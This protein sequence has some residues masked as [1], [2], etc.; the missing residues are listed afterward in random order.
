M[1]T[2]TFHSADRRIDG[3]VVEGH[4]GYAEAGSDIVCAAISSVVGVTECTI[5][6]VLGLAAPVKV[7]EK[8]GFVSLKLP[9]SLGQANERTCQDLLTG[10]MVYLQAL[11][12]EY[13]ENLIVRLDDED[14]DDEE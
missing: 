7:R 1:T 2:V 3:F 9:G 13:P 5:N 6:D 10:M 14:D 8:D 11:S 4:S 12:E